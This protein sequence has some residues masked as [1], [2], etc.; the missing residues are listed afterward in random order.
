MFTGKVYKE[1]GVGIILIQLNIELTVEENDRKMSVRI[2]SVQDNEEFQSEGTQSQ[3]DLDEFIEERKSASKIQKLEMLKDRRIQKVLY[4][5]MYICES[6]LPQEI[7]KLD[8]ER[9]RKSTLSDIQSEEFKQLSTRYNILFPAHRPSAD[10]S[11]DEF[12]VGY[13]VRVILKLLSLGVDQEE[14]CRRVAGNIKSV[15]DI[16]RNHDAINPTGGIQSQLDKIFEGRKKELKISKSEML[17]NRE[18]ALVL[19]PDMYICESDLPEKIM[20]LDMKRLRKLSLHDTQ[21]EEFKELS[22]RYNILFPTQ[23]PSKNFSDLII[24]RLK[25]SYSVVQRLHLNKKRFT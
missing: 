8:M 22:T 12:L 16:A 24:L 13:R 25:K 19:F 1:S 6:D 17:K 5:D 10:E 4:P 3:L 21:S 9:L 23:K 11:T 15:Q 20:K 7:M 14:E 2:K 18:I